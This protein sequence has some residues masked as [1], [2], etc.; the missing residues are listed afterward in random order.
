[1]SNLFLLAS[2]MVWNRCTRVQRKVWRWGVSISP[3]DD[4]NGGFFVLVNDEAQHSRWLTFA[5]VPAGWRVVYGEADRAACLDHI[6]QNW[7]DIRRR[8]V[9]ARG[10]QRAG[11][12]IR[13]PW[14]LDF[15]GA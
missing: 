10:S 9:C 8:R 6:G 11:V 13:K 7:A 15:D 2:S 14:G 12:L 1:M 5:D 3:F 4:D